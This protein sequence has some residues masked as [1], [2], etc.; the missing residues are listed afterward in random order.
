MS[1]SHDPFLKSGKR[2]KLLSAITVILML[3]LIW[4]GLSEDARAASDKKLTKKQLKEI[5]ADFFSVKC[6]IPRK[7]ILKSD[8]EFDTEDGVHTVIIERFAKPYED[9]CFNTRW[10]L[11]YVSGSGE[12]L[13]WDAHGGNYNEPDPDHWAMG[14]ETQPDPRF[15]QRDEVLA[16]CRLDFARKYGKELPEEYSLRSKFIFHEAFGRVPTGPIGGQDQLNTHIPVWLIYICDSQGRLCWKA[17]YSHL[18]KLISLVTA[19][20]DFETYEIPGENFLGEVYGW[21]ISVQREMG[22]A[23]RDTI[24]KKYS[25]S[26]SDE[27]ILEWMAEWA[28]KYKAWLQEHPYSRYGLMEDLLEHYPQFR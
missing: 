14:E 2:S 16:Q 7:I 26:V 15:A 3:T 6:G 25:Y 28:P 11:L 4:N 5:A 9:H 22:T 19:E 17:V 12:I 23:I 8:F 10:H 24:N 21:D 18:G 27:Q 13:S 1:F 20:Q